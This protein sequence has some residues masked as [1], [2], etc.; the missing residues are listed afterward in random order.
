MSQNVAVYKQSD[1]IF[2]I[3]GI[4]V[5]DI[6]EEGEIRVTYDRSRIEKQKDTN[7]GGL[8]SWRNGKPGAIEVPILPHSRWVAYLMNYRNLGKMCAVSLKD[9]NDY[10]SKIHYE[11]LYTMVQDPE[12]GYGANAE[13]MI[14]RFECM[15]LDDLTANVDL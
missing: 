8:F 6:P 12:K 3:F 1:V 7:L 10:E 5:D 11:S 2:S 9:E 13:A 15:Q 14:F 4:P